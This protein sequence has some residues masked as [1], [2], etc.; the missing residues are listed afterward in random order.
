MSR[1][2]EVPRDQLTPEQRDVYDRIASG[3]RGGVRGPFHPLIQSP[4]LAD[5]V[6][7]LGQYVR[8]DCSIPQKLRELAILITARH[9]GAQYEW[10]AHAPHAREAGLPDAVIEAIRCNKRPDFDD[11]AEQEIYNFCTELYTNRRIS[12]DSY[13]KIV[14]RHGQAGAVDLAGLLGHYNVIS[15]TLNT[16]EVEVPGGERPLPD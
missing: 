9:W 6:Q 11:A 2:P 13:D 8:Y 15:I 12:D 5:C 4:V 7:K 16:F 10:F 1:I 14:D 3:P